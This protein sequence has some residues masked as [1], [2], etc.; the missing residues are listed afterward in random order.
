[1]CRRDHSTNVAQC[2]NSFN[3]PNDDLPVQKLLP[4]G[5]RI[6]NLV[7][8]AYTAY[9]MEGYDARPYD[10]SR[11]LIEAMENP[12]SLR[13]WADGKSAFSQAAVA[14]DWSDDILRQPSEMLKAAQNQW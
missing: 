14:K 13:R 12:A 4:V 6:S 1:M 9:K 3:N 5:V 2:E 11:G 10:L 7:L 8:A